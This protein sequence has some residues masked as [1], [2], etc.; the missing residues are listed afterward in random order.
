M[1]GEKLLKMKK[2]IEE[3]KAEKSRLEGKKEQLENQLKTQFKCESIEEAK[4][5]LSVL[6]DELEELQKLILGKETEIE[7][8]Y[9]KLQE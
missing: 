1:D 8:K 9:E 2:K 4:K 3:L 7:K 5:Y 6:E